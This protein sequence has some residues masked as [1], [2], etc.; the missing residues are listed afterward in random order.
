[1]FVGNPTK[2]HFKRAEH[3]GFSSDDTHDALIVSSVGLDP[4]VQGTVIKDRVETTQIA[5]TALKALGLDPEKLQGAEAEDTQQLPGLKL[6]AVA[7]RHGDG[8]QALQQIDHFM[9]IY[10]ENWSFDGLYGGF[11]GA[12]GIANA[13]ATSMSQIDRQTGKPYTSE[14]GQ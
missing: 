13:S 9:V 3:G 6:E 8:R 1:I 12:N 5:V 7:G 2:F 14:M 4:S 10:Q 11:P